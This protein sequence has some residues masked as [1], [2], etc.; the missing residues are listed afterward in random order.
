MVTGL[1]R[2]QRLHGLSVRAVFTEN[3]AGIAIARIVTMLPNYGFP[4][5]SRHTLLASTQH[6]LVTV[7]QGKRRGR[8]VP[9]LWFATVHNSSR[10]LGPDCENVKL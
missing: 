2:I 8:L 7:G 5:Q 6:V 4:G 1:G 9:V 3:A 10:V